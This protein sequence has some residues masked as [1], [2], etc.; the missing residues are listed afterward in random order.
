MKHLCIVLFFLFTATVAFAQTGTLAYT[1]TVLGP[2]PSCTLRTSS[3]LDFGAHTRSSSGTDSEDAVGEFTLTGT[4][5]SEYEVSVGSLPTTFPNL[6]VDL[7]LGWSQS[8]TG[9]RRSWTAISGSTYTGT[10]GGLWTDLTHYFQISGQA[11]W[12]W[13]D[14]T[15]IGSD[16]FTVDVTVSCTRTS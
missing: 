9:L 6:D 10:A 16:N 1:L 2:D 8:T 3:Q 14:I 12:D 5:V 13:E 4:D 7:N 11:S 15:S